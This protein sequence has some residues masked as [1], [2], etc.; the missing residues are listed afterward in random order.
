VEFL[1]EILIALV[2]L[3]EAEAR[4]FRRGLRNLAIA[5][6]LLSGGLIFLVAGLG[7][8]LWGVY[9]PIAASVG[10]IGAAFIL[11]GISLTVTL[12]LVIVA[13]WLTR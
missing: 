2:D 12:V 10:R 9:M 3:L 6:M 7:L 5:C 8:M 13:R 11:G 1:A 4:A